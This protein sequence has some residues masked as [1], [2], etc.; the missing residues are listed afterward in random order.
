MINY[1]PFRFFSI[2]LNLKIRFTN[3]NFYASPTSILFV[4]RKRVN[5]IFFF[6]A[7]SFLLVHTVV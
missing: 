7:G 2:D 3:I 1:V 6:Y 4:L 5:L